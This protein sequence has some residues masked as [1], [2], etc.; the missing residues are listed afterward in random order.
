M[1]SRNSFSSP[2]QAGGASSRPLPPASARRHNRNIA[3]FFFAVAF[4]VFLR[5]CVYG[6]ELSVHPHCVPE[7][8][9]CAWDTG[10]MI[11]VSHITETVDHAQAVIIRG[12]ERIYLTTAWDDKMGVV[13][14]ASKRHFNAEPYRFVS[15]PDFINEQIKFVK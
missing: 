14:V 3:I 6:Q 9:Y 15:L 13:C 5:G 4:V 12:N 2:Q 11:A 10:A 8:I 7:A 1:S